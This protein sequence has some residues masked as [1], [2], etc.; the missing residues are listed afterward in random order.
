M[1]L[2]K[3]VTIIYS[4]TYLVC[5]SLNK[6]Y[7]FRLIYI[8]LI[9]NRLLDYLLGYTSFIYILNTRYVYLTSMPVTYRLGLVYTDFNS[10]L[11]SV[12]LSFIYY[13]FL[14]VAQYKLVDLCLY[15]YCNKYII[16]SL[17]YYI[18][19]LNNIFL[20]NTL[21]FTKLVLKKSI[22]R[23]TKRYE[24]KGYMNYYS[25]YL[26]KPFP[27]Y[28]LHYSCHRLFTRQVLGCL[29][30]IKRV[31]SYYFYK[32]FCKDWSQLALYRNDC[33]F[34][35]KAYL[36]YILKYALFLH[37]NSNYS[38]IAFFG[39]ILLYIYIFDMSLGDRRVK[40][41]LFN[42]DFFYHNLIFYFLFFKYMWMHYYFLVLC[43]HYNISVKRSFIYSLFMYIRLSY[44]QCYLPKFTWLQKKDIRNI[45]NF[46]TLLQAKPDQ[47]FV[48]MPFT[49]YESRYIKS[50]FIY[51]YL[52]YRVK[53][54]LFFI[55]T[56]KFNFLQTGHNLLYKHGRRKRRLVKL[57]LMYYIVLLVNSGGLAFFCRQFKYINYFNLLAPITSNRILSRKY[58]SDSTFIFS[59]YKMSFIKL[60]IKVLFSCFLLIPQIFFD[61]ELSCIGGNFF[62][63]RLYFYNY[64][65]INI[66]IY[67]RLF[68]L[69]NSS[70]ILYII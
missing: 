43:T 7:Y 15:M 5:Y 2:L 4:S 44:S 36:K 48:I 67:I 51:L 58:Y 42:L 11:F 63:F 38:I 23:K 22:I 14:I 57:Q 9:I 40:Y 26:F 68:Y 55:D 53:R 24:V 59:I 20:W 62:F 1:L 45:N 30:N 19:N 54:V 8:L 52:H 3:K 66:Y 41:K 50:S 64:Y 46:R 16:Y 61:R 18:L 25:T 37:F 12:K 65:V 27:K 34:L 69:Y 21:S 32:N 17:F 56:L 39:N 60:F 29:P 70:K 33:K 49:T 6:G 35:L 13:F 28:R 47:L 31:R 10:F